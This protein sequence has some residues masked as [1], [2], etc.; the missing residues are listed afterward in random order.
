[1]AMLLLMKTV[2]RK[3]AV[4][5]SAIAVTDKMIGMERAPIVKLAP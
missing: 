3:Q 2:W 4:V 5:T 1:M